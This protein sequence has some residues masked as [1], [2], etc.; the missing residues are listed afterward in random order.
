MHD[1]IYLVLQHHGRGIVEAHW[2]RCGNDGVV[3]I[4][5]GLY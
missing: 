2:T 5:D 1:V 3:M 4:V